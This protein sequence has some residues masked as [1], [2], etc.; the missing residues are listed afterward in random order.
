M[1]SFSCGADGGIGSETSLFIGSFNVNSEDLTLADA[2]A[3]LKRAGDADIVALG[4]QVG[5]RR[6]VLLIFLLLL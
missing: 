2:R 3:W 6:W 5:T 4:L 1:A